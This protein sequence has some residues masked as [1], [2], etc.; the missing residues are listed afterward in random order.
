[1]PDVGGPL[2]EDLDRLLQAST[3]TIAT[4]VLNVWQHEPIDVGRWWH[5][6]PEDHR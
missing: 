5:G 6:L 3:V 4:G 1:M 2:F